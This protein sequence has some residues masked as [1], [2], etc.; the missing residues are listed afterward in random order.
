M[1]SL[2][3]MPVS[4]N[5][6]I[7]Q[8][9][10]LHTDYCERHAA[11]ANPAVQLLIECHLEQLSH[12]LRLLREASDI[13]AAE[14]EWGAI[15]ETIERGD[16]VMAQN[17]NNTYFIYTCDECFNSLT[18]RAVS[19]DEADGRLSAYGWDKLV[20]VSVDW[21]EHGASRYLCHVHSGLSQE[22]GVQS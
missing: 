7:D 1:T 6:V 18:I 4:L 5:D 8:I 11:T 21:T 15:G 10:E 16:E 9:D 2:Q 14:Q 17:S 3:Q 12:A 13:L 20:R 19:Q 22:G